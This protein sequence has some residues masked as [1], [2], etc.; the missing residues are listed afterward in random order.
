LTHQVCANKVFIDA[1]A[2]IGTPLGTFLNGLL[3]YYAARIV[4]LTGEDLAALH[5]PCAVL[6]VTH[7]ELFDFGRHRVQVELQGEHT[8]GMTVVDRRIA[9]TGPV[10]VA[11]NV[12][13]ERVLA[14]IAQAI[15]A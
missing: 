13:A 7:P 5:D 9:D 6:A 4:E 8:R 15:S 3:T 12:D 10:E 2:G 1:L 11:W 14:L